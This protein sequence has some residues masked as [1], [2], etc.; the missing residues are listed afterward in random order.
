MSRHWKTAV[1]FSQGFE[2]IEKP[3]TD[4]FDLVISNIPFGD[5]AVFDPEFTG[6]HDPARRSAAKQLFGVDRADREVVRVG[7][8]IIDQCH[9]SKIGEMITQNILFHFRGQSIDKINL[10]AIDSG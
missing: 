5:V 7:T 2:K 8:L 6:S 1:H 9:R 10:S 4:Y 3:F